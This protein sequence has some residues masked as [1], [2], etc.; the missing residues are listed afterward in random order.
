MNFLEKKFT[1]LTAILSN[2]RNPKQMVWFHKHVS[3][4]INKSIDQVW[5]MWADQQLICLST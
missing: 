1:F 5:G 2:E 3:A 4:A